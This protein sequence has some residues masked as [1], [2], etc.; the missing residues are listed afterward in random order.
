MAT[1]SMAVVRD[2]HACAPEEIGVDLTGVD[3]VLQLLQPG[4]AAA[5]EGLVVHVD[6]A[7]HLVQ[8]G[9]ALVGVPLAREARQLVGDLVE[10]DPVAAV[11]A[12]GLAEGDLAAGELVADDLGDLAH[13]V[14]LLAAS[15]R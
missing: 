3:Q 12:A 13:P 7:E 8:L 5:G 4:V 11:V 9:G 15:R 10:G 2:D 6:A 14:V 1:P